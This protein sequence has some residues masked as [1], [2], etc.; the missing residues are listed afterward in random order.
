MEVAKFLGIKVIPKSFGDREYGSYSPEA[1][2]IQLCTPD[3]TTF[4]HELAHAVD[5]YLMK[6]KEG[7]GLKGGQHIDQELV[8]Q[9]AANT[10]AYMRGY[11]IEES[12]AYTKKYIESYAGK[13]HEMLLIRLMARIERIV[14]FIT[15]YKGAESPKVEME[16]KEG[17]EETKTEIL[18]D[19]PPEDKPEHGKLYQLTGV[20]GS[21]AISEGKSWKEAEVFDGY[22][23]ADKKGGEKFLTYLRMEGFRAMELSK[24]KID[25]LFRSYKKQK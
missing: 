6:L 19:H 16:K 14:E 13:D 18:A 2:V 25:R 11:K 1:K 5:D 21:N 9:F 10:I 8:A 17:K 24:S 20:A 4:Y 12:T 15:N 7:K 3:E 23:Y 22:S